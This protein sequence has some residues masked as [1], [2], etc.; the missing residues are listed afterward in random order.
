[1][2]E[3]T[4]P[5]LPGIKRSL[6]P[7]TVQRVRDGI[8]RYGPRFTADNVLRCFALFLDAVLAPPTW[9]TPGTLYRFMQDQACEWAE[10]T[11]AQVQANSGDLETTAYGVLFVLSKRQEQEQHT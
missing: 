10:K 4:V 11:L 2:T 8:T 7:E 6:K 3:P 9:P 5:T 1:V